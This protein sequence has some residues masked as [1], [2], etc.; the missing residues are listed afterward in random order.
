[1]KIKKWFVLSFCLLVAVL[2]G[3]RDFLEGFE[4]EYA[5]YRNPALSPDESQVAFE[6]RDINVGMEGEDRPEKESDIFLVDIKGE[7]LRQ[8]TFYS[9]GITLSPDK[10]QVLLQTYYGLYLLD[11]NKKTPP[12]QVFNRFPELALDGRYGSV[13]QLS[14]SPSGRKFFFDRAIG[15]DWERKY[16]ILDAKTLEERLFDPDLGN[17]WAGIQWIDDNTIIF[18]RNNEILIYNYVT[19]QGDLLASGLPNAPCTNP[20]PSPDMQRFL[21]RYTDQYKVRLGS[22]MKIVVCQVNDLP[23]WASDELTKQLW[24]G[25]ENILKKTDYLLLDGS[26]SQVKVSW[27]RDS[28]RL[29]IK[30]QKELWI[31]NLSDS[32]YTPVF[33]DSIPITEAVLTPDQGKI[34][35]LSYFWG[36]RDGDGRLSRYEKISDLKVY[37]LRSKKCRIILNHSDPAAQLSL[38]P[39]GKFLAFVKSDNIWVLNTETEDVFQLTSDGG[40]NPQW[41]AN[42][43]ALLFTEKGSLVR[44]D[45]KDKKYTYLTLGRGVEPN[46]LNNGEII[47]K[48]GGKFWKISLDRFEVKEIETYPDKP[49]MTKGKKYEVYIEDVELEPMYKNISAIKAKNVN[50]SE[51]WTIKQPWCNFPWELKK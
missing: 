33:L 26:I 37:N 3:F 11:L 46:W 7:N 15:L 45:L 42:S 35:F 51:Y 13:E 41:L 19:R 31:Y 29:L 16:S 47:L 4:A 2:F 22:R 32:S 20:I 30:G 38:S 25:K 44:V 36:D 24:S 28:Q 50:T 6:C 14:W 12:R 39:D 48:S 34:F 23:D 18:E 9:E 10:S 27:F 21:Y 40:I 43:K 49:R 1:M 8:L 5:L 17:F